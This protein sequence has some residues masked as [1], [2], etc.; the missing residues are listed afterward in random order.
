MNTSE[1]NNLEGLKTI[2]DQI[3]KLA[4]H[5][6]IVLKMAHLEPTRQTTIEAH[7]D[8][9]EDVCSDLADTIVKLNVKPL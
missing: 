3:S 5:A 8:I 9:L 7:L 4:F 1:T 6:E 2:S